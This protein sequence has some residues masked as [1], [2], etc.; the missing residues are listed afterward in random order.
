[1]AQFSIDTLIPKILENPKVQKTL[2]KLNTL[3]QE[4]IAK[5]D[6]LRGRL[7]K[8]RDATVKQALQ[9]YHEVVKTMNE[10]E[11][12]V[13]S[14]KKKALAERAKLEKVFFGKSKKKSTKKT[15][16]KAT[17]K[18]ATSTSKKTSKKAATKK[19]K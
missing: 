3:S 2:A 16:V 18:A 8:E 14:Y 17:K 12:S 11:K 19:S 13:K 4:L 10:L 7:I 5:E 1:M 15:A 9:K 6:E